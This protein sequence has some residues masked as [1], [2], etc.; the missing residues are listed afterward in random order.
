MTPCWTNFESWLDE[1][2]WK[3]EHQQWCGV[4]DAPDAVF[5]LLLIFTIF[6]WSGVLIIAMNR[7]QSLTTMSMIFFG[8]FQVGQMKAHHVCLF[9]LFHG[10]LIAAGSMYFAIP[11]PFRTRNWKNVLAKPSSVFALNPSFDTFDTFLEHLW[12]L[13]AEVEATQGDAT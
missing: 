3:A 11:V 7:F 6:L 13:V 1:D 9:G 10:Y 8:L 12:A 4:N 2:H 5:F